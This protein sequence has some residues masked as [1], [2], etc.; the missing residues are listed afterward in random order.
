MK[1]KLGVVDLLLHYPPKGGAC[2]DLFSVLKILSCDFEIKLFCPNWTSDASSRGVFEEAPPFPAEVIEMAKPS[3]ESVLK[4]FSEALDVWG[5][6]VV[7]V[8]DGW[9]LKPYLIEALRRRWPLAARLYA[10][11]GLCPRNNERWL[12]D[13]RCPNHALLDAERCVACAKSYFGIVREKRRGGDNPLTEEMRI[14]DIF[15]GDYGATLRAAFN[16]LQTIVYNRTAAGILERH[17]NAKAVIAPGGVDTELFHPSRALKGGSPFEILVAGRMGDYAKGASTAIE[18]GALLASQGRNFRMTVTR[19]STASS[20]AAPWLNECGWKG[21]AELSEMMRASD[22]A[23]VPSLWEEAFGMVWAEAMASGLPVI[24]SAVPGPLEYLVDGANG[25]L[26]EAG[27]AKALAERIARLMDDASLRH[28]LAD[29]GL[30]LAN[31][32]LTW[33]SAAAKTKEAILSALNV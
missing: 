28:R 8:A 15:S 33:P 17:G 1:P 4:A 24:A 6:D 27:D 30:S 25:L 20:L 3:R 7:L 9:T 14:A 13:G 22:C 21:R 10:Y 32:R 26:F 12:P 18:A 31:E 2:V 16:G 11:E 19:P 23:V 5:P 29:A